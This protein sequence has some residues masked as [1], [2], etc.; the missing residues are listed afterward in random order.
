MFGSGC[1]FLTKILHTLAFCRWVFGFFF[2]FSFLAVLCSAASRILVPGPGIK[3]V[4][5]AVKVWSPYHWTTREAS[6]PLLLTWLWPLASS[7]APSSL[8]LAWLGI[9]SASVLQDI[10]VAGGERLHI[11]F[12]NTKYWAFPPRGKF[13]SDKADR[14]DLTPGWGRC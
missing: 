2:S 13:C 4:P 9:L 10:W 6:L 5:P 11:Y 12:P 7:K 3:P 8:E 14:L 1:R